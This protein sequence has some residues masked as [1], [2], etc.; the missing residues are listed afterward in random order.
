MNDQ[1]EKVEGNGEKGLAKMGDRI[2][3]VGKAV[4]HIKDQ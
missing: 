4:S 1:F 2:G 3:H